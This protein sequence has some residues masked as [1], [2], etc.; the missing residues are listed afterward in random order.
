MGFTMLRNGKDYLASLRDGRRIRLGS[1]LVT[2]VTTHPAFRNTAQSFARI[3]DLKRSA[4]HADYMSYEEDGQ[5]YSA[6]FK[7]PKSKEDLQLRAEAHRRVA[8]WSCGLLGRSMDHV[9]SFIA[10]MSMK[11]ELFDAN[12]DGFGQNITSYLDYLRNEDLFACYLVLTPQTSRGV[13][14]PAKANFR[15]VGEY[16]G[17]IIVSGQKMLGTSAVFSHEAWIGS[18]IPLGP[19]QVEEAVTFALPI[20]APGVELWVRKSFELNAR[21]RIDN[22]FSS[23]F[24]ESDAVMIFNDVKVPWERVFCYRDIPLMRDMYFKTPAHMLGNH[25]SNWRFAEKLKLINGIAHQAADYGGLLGVPAIQQTLG[26]LAAGEATLLGLLSAQVDQFQSLP[27][28]HVH[29]NNRFLYAALQ[30]CARSYHEI[31]EDVRLLL[32]AGPFTIPADASILE[33][34]EANDIFEANWKLP[35]ASADE[36]YRFVRMAWD[37]LGSDYAG[38]HQQYE[39][40]Y[41]GPP[42]IMDLYSF[43]HAPWA[44]R[45]QGVQNILDDMVTPP[46]RLA[47]E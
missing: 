27:T 42:H 15:I 22:Y 19:D 43:W 2:D 13:V 12:R 24:D 9:P 18:M 26:R 17:G 10:G 3:Y 8:E 46:K 30:W 32:G 35:G 20:N 40:F 33:D 5:R 34:G 28:G 6:W 23:Q 1:E 41:G 11:P 45:R 29:V 31:A 4:E 47:A 21:N 38:R 39:R 44:E 14:G 7:V 25:Q 36:R 37:L 16:D